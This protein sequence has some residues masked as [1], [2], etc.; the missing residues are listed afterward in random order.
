MVLGLCL[1]AGSSIAGYSSVP[2]VTT[3]QFHSQDEYGQYSYGYTGDSSAKQETK[4]VD[5]VTRGSY[6]YVDAN[7]V[8]QTTYYVS[9]PVHGFRV[10]ATNLPKEPSAVIAGPSAV[11][12]TSPVRS[13]VHSIP[14]TVLRPVTSTVVHSLPT[15]ATRPVAPAYIQSYAS[16]TVHSSS[17]VTYGF[18]PSH[19]LHS[20]SASHIS[21]APGFDYVNGVPLDT[22]EVAAAKAAHYA[23]HGEALAR[24]GKRWKRSL[25]SSV[26][27]SSTVVSGPGGS[28]SYSTV[29]HTPTI[30]VPS[31]TT[32][33]ILG[34]K[35]LSY[36][37]LSPVG[38]A[39]SYS[40]ISP[41]P[42]GRQFSYSTAAAAPL[43]TAPKSF[44]LSTHYPVVTPV[45]HHSAPVTY[46][47]APVVA[48]P[49]THSTQYGS[50]DN[51][52]QYSYGYSD[53]H[54]S[55]TESRTAGGVTRGGYSYVDS[56]GVVQT[57][58]YVADA[59]G[60]RV[61]ATNLPMA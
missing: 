53:G 45:V 30:A 25:S 35:S 57:V 14:S 56:N 42:T 29:A 28:F 23:A 6:S 13:A 1:M 16:P 54:S 21:Q 27:Q 19:G 9:D 4:T 36:S 26:P 43:L 10:A 7:G 24:V 34:S 37:S 40:S 18:V 22:P 44:S 8:L 47:T 39:K 32:H 46:T 38:I 60:F 41:V 33:S 50:Q 31:Y 48:V 2:Y 5:G 61:H 55:K 20:V 12:S 52:G 58:K 49:V 11:V 17:P 51:Y 15:P 59:A 3:S